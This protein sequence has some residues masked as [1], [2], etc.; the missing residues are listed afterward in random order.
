MR[1]HCP[2]VAESSQLMEQTMAELNFSVRPHDLMLKVAP[3][4]AHLEKSEH[5]QSAHILQAIQCRSLG[6]SMW[7]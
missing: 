3:T 1:E 4:L 7:T 6:R 5:I 2:I